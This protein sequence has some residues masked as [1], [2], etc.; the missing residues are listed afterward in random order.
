MDELLR[1]TPVIDELGALFHKAGE[2]LYLV[3]GSVRDALLGRLGHDLDFTTSADPD[4]TERLLHRFSSAVWTVGK[5]FGT[6]GASKKSNGHELQIEITTFRADAY[7]PDS[8]KP[9]VAYGD[10]VQDDLVRRD[11]TVNAM[12]IDVHSKA[13]V[14]PHGG[15]RDLAAKVLRTPTAPEISFSDDP[16]RMMRACRFAAQLGFKVD[17]VTFNAMKAMH[18]RIEI[19]SPERVRDELSKLLLADAPRPGL[20]LLVASGLADIVLPEL[21]AMRLERDEHFRHKDV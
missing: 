8:R 5:E 2:E 6:I 13:F 14:D 7:E 9:I 4:T 19:V 11:F 12:A 21:P 17:P 16:L 3:G 1:I 15:I 20:N 18:E 10:N